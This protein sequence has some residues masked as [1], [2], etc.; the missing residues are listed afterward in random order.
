M[1]N[2][3]RSK[4]YAVVYYDE[5]GRAFEQDGRFFDG[6]GAPWVESAPAGV[7]AEA[8]PAKPPAKAAPKAKPAAAT[9]ADEQLAAQM[10]AGA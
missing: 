1:A 10:V 8:A 9:P 2:L 7:T 5:Q 3:D 4:P 6:S